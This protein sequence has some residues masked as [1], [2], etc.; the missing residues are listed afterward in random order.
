MINKILYY[1][2]YSFIRLLALLPFPIIYGISDLL[3]PFVY[4]LIGYRKKVVRENIKNSFP[5]YSTKK[6]R[7][8]ER[9]FYRHF[10]DVVFEIIKLSNISSKEIR[11]RAKLVNHEELEE[12]LMQSEANAAILMMAHSGNWEWYSGSQVF[13]KQIKMHEI[14]RPLNSKAFDRLFLKLRQRY[15][16]ICVQKAQ[17]VRESIRLSQINNP[18]SLI[19]FIAD[20]TPSP[21]NIHYW[22]DFLSQKTP[23]LTGAERIAKKLNL[24]VYYIETKMVKR[25]YY[26]VRS[27]PLTLD[28]KTTSEF[29]IT[30]KFARK[31]E[32]DI[33]KA[34]E[35]WLW[36]HKR[37]KHKNLA[38]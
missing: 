31:L 24:P 8:I 19:I 33:I 15:G 4:Y 22:T 35:Q 2:V 26:E 27:I 1:I 13:F 32:Q 7:K 9:G 20:Q 12:Q 29:E 6:L 37:W 3:F 5:N 21:N 28:P 11:K 10:I 25:G 17:S 23:F 16:S 38:P 30:E 36:S 34:P 18:K 14:Y